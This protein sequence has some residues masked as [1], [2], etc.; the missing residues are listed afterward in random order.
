L[1]HPQFQGISKESRNVGAKF[2]VESLVRAGMVG[3]YPAF[4]GLDVKG[5]H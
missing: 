5:I 1:L 3:G 4:V 2:G